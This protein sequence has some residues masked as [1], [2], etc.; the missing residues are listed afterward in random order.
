M[1]ENGAPY[2]PPWSQNTIFSTLSQ[3]GLTV[4]GTNKTKSAANDREAAIFPVSPDD[5]IRHVARKIR[6]VPANPMTFGVVMVH[7]APKG[8]AAFAN[9]PTLERF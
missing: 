3:A 2:I 1:T 9:F 8:R 7:V 4:A 6:A 5:I